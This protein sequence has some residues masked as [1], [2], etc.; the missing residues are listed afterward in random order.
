VRRYQS[1]LFEMHKLTKMGIFATFLT[2][3]NYQ[4]TKQ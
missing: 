2:I 1:S 4:I 3:I